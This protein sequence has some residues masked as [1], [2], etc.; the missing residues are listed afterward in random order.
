MRRSAIAT[1][2]LGARVVPRI[3]V[4]VTGIPRSPWLDQFSAPRASRVPSSDELGELGPDSVMSR[5]SV[6]AILDSLARS[7]VD[8]AALLWIAEYPKASGGICGLVRVGL[9]SRLSKKPPT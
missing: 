4:V 5:R 3:P 1:S 7:R 6:P 2:V 9:F 8:G